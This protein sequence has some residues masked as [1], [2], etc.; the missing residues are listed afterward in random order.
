MKWLFLM[1]VAL[2][3]TAGAEAKEVD[4]LRS[5]DDMQSGA[6][7]FDRQSHPGRAL[8]EKN[9][10]HCHNGLVP[11][12]PGF[13][14]VEMMSPAAVHDA[15]N[16]GIMKTEAAHLNDNQRLQITE[17]I[18]R[19][20]IK[21]LDDIARPAPDYCNDRR[22]DKRRIPPAVNWGHDTSRFSPADVAGLSRTDLESLEIKWGY[23][24]P[25]AFRA[26]SQPAI[27]HGAIY[28]GSQDGT[29][30]AFDLATGCVKW[31][32]VASAEVRTGIVLSTDPG[33]PM[34]F[35]GDILARLYAVNA[36]T[37]ELV[38]SMKAD[39]HPNAT[40]TGTPAYD[41]GRLF[42]P[43]SSL[44]VI[45]AADPAYACCTFKGR[46]LS[47]DAVTGDELWRHY[48]I[49]KKPETVATTPVGTK[50][51]AP[52]GAPIWASPTIDSKRN[53]LYVGTGENYSS[54]ADGNSDA[55]LAIDLSTGKRVWTHQA[56]AGDAWNVAC[57]MEDNPNCP[58]EDGPDFLA[59]VSCC[60]NCLRVK[61]F[62]WRVIRTV[63]FL[64][65]IRKTR[66]PSSGRQK[67]AEVVSRAGC[68]LVWRHRQA[69]F[70]SR[71]MT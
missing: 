36:L 30:Y 69:R 20:R 39:D 54:P 68:I 32:F 51:L 2:S 61:I 13:N 53:R 6:A 25:G 65:S 29:V 4:T 37:G 15:L 7:D 48:T 57:M 11:K 38:W 16:T 34:A 64:V 49:E 59:P 50:V 45:P 1:C 67:L 14:W 33:R 66:Q 42:V 12:A 56:T 22:V 55:I 44:E 8:Y 63:S 21:T 31:V 60:T 17:Y 62:F 46:I 19:T 27:G 10:N 26:R 52:S 41:G 18:T 35:F 43:V 70:M 5:T 71:S 23:V 40:M 24:Y 58:A 47:V 28:T 3:Q 9:C